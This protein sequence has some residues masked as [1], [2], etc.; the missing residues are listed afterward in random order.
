MMDAR[1]VLAHVSSCFRRVGVG[2]WCSL[3]KKH[4]AAD[5][6]LHLANC[7]KSIKF[8]R[9]RHFAM[10]KKMRVGPISENCPDP[11]FLDGGSCAQS[12]H[13]ETT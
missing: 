9:N 1:H 6:E 13:E 2:T 8:G 4:S 11:L 3:F 7:D 5:N 12:P 10:L